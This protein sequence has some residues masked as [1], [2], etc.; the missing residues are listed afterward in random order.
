MQTEITT[1]FIMPGD[2]PGLDDGSSG[3]WGELTNWYTKGMPIEFTGHGVSD[4]GD[5]VFS[6]CPTN[7]PFSNRLIDRF[8]SPKPPARS[9]WIKPPA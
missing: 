5:L 4:A 6:V 3:L 9:L 7:R 1:K 8:D 2:Q